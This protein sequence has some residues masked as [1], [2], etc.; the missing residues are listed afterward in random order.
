MRIAKHI[1]K[2]IIDFVIYAGGLVVLLAETIYFIITPP[3]VNR[4]YIMDQMS[5]V[6][7]ASFPIVFVFSLFVG[8][9][10]AVQSAYQMQ[11]L[12]AEMY[13]ASLVSLS[14][15]REL[16][17]VLTAMVVAG[18]V[19]A[20]IAAELGTMRVTEQIDALE[21]LGSNPVRF[22]VVP[23]FLALIVMLP[24]LTIMADFLGIIGGFLIGVYKL[25]ISPSMYLN[26]SYNPLILKDV[27][28]GLTKSVFFAVIICIVGCYQ[29]MNTKGGAEGVGLATTYSVVISFL[30]IIAADLFL[31]AFFY[32]VI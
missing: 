20:S 8:M 15:V 14:M 22:L 5:K 16:G 7:I 30:L 26:M 19:G 11:K 18:R 23:R 17:P 29:G 27:F 3:A 28:S 13:I 4:K 1:G 24:V 9:V 25:G 21:T 31:T 12:S 2:T 32:F 10:L 6:G